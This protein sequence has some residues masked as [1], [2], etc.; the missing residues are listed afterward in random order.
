MTRE[1]EIRQ[2]LYHPFYSPHF[3]VCEST[4]IDSQDTENSHSEEERANKR[5]TEEGILLA[6]NSEQFW[7]HFIN[8]KTY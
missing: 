6:A 8:P 7:R 5:D 1:T 2:C 3:K 4:W